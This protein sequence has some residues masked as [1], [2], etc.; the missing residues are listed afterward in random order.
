MK[1]NKCKSKKAKEKNLSFSNS[2]KSSESFS[3]NFWGNEKEKTISIIQNNSTQSEQQR[4]N[5]EIEA[6]SCIYI[7]AIEKVIFEANGEHELIVTLKPNHFN[8]TFFDPI[9]W[10]KLKIKYY[11]GYPV[12]PAGVDII[13][14]YNISEIEKESINTGLDDIVNIRSDQNCE[15]INDVLEYVRKF[16]DEKSKTYSPFKRK[17]NPI[18][19]ISGLKSCRKM[20]SDK[21]DEK[22]SVRKNLKKLNYNKGNDLLGYNYTYNSSK[23]DYENVDTNI[24]GLD[25]KNFV[26]N[27]KSRMLT[28]FQILDKIGEGGGGSVYKV[29]NNFDG[30]FYAIKKVILFAYSFLQSHY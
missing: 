13:E 24:E 16:L 29:K 3:N 12:I 22:K 21:Y 19:D 30:M 14:K 1:S 9:C 15:M 5:N 23:I 8:S 7:D 26:S 25:E 2:Q 4:I 6:L 20:S 18:E 28:D 27:G 10:I 17:K 11:I